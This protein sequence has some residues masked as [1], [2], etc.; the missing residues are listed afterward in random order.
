ME[1]VPSLNL[2][3]WFSS[4]GVTDFRNSCARTA[5]QGHRRGDV[6]CS[7]VKQSELLHIRID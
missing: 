2:N 1:L 7:R 4:I 6:G 3:L 5:S